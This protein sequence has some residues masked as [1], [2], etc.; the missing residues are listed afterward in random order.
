MDTERK[1]VG[2]AGLEA[3]QAAMEGWHARKRGRERIPSELWQS[4]AREVRRY[5]LNRVSQ[6][7]RLNY[8]ELKR[9]THADGEA[10]YDAGNGCPHLVPT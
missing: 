8:A 6:A 9:Q 10:T 5:G 3:V 1:G 2:Q 7:L 4:V